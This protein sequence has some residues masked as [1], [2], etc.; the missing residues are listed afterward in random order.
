MTESSSQTGVTPRQKELVQSTWEQ[1]V[2]ISDAAGGMFYGR[3]FELDP[4][5]RALFPAGDEAMQSQSR[6]LMQMIGT[7]VRGLDQPDEIVPAVRDLGRRHV[8]YGVQN[9]DYETVGAALLWT[10]EQ[11]LGDAF[12]P[13]VRDAWAATY[14]LLAGLMQEAAPTAPA[15]HP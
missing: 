6:K 4:Q 5:L 10:L 3:L 9:G 15:I 7:A 14:A 11:G 12:A 2:P 8:A 13:Q 1:V